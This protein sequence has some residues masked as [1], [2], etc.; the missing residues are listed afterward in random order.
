MSTSSNFF[1]LPIAHFGI[2]DYLCK[3]KRWSKYFARKCKYFP[4]YSPLGIEFA[5]V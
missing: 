4:D 3:R 5:L 2:I 1:A